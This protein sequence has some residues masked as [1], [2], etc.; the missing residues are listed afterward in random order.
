[1][2]KDAQRNWDVER[3]PGGNYDEGRERAWTERYGV[4]MVLYKLPPNVLVPHVA[5][6][7]RIAKRDVDED[8]RI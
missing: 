3:F 2:L 8:V 6:F 5:D 7:L 4:L 1:M